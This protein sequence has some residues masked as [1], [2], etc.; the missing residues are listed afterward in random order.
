MDFEKLTRGIEIIRK[1]GDVNSITGLTDDSREVR[2]GYAFIAI[3]GQIYDGHSF[4]KEAQEKNAGLLVL[5][6]KVNASIPFIIVPNTHHALSVMSSNFYGNPSEDMKVIGITGTN[7][8][9]TTAY[10]LSSIYSNSIL[11]STIKYSSPYSEEQPVNTTPNPIILHRELKD[12]LTKGIDTAIIEVSSHGIIQNRIS[13]VNF[14]YAIFTNLSRDH[15]DY[16]GTFESYR[17]SKTRFF[18][19]MGED[20]MSIINIDD[21]NSNHFI[22]NTESKVITYGL[23]KSC[24]VRGTITENKLGKLGVKIEGMGRKFNVTSS[25]SGS[26]NA[27]NITAASALAISD[28]KS[29]E[30]IIKGIE[31]CKIPPGRTEIMNVQADFN[32]IVDYA[33]T[34]DGLRQLLESI[35]ELTSGRIITV[36]GAGGDRDRGKRTEMGEIVS[37]LSDVIVLTSDNPRSENP[38]NIIEDIK[39][40]VKSENYLAIIKRREAIIRALKMAEPGD[41]V[42]VA[43]KGHEEYQVVGNKKIPY[44]DRKFI[45][46]YF[47]NEGT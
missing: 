23:K 34:P 43:G 8:K 32:V 14:D 38:E 20:K 22:K 2:P 44:S 30:S 15:L 41:T 7:G 47:K 17:S 45:R 24:T 16:H 26:H 9:T 19:A 10:L 36:F 1:K 5:E 21:D 46:R 12:A 18:K 33:H 31:S 6:E 4:W 40:G 37:E 39:A 29:S 11:F 13:A 35:K 25:F 27:Y 42:I 28:N 3:K